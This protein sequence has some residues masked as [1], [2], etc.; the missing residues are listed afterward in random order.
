LVFKVSGHTTWSGV[1]SRKYYPAR[2][3]V[4]EVKWKTDKLFQVTRCVVEWE[5]RKGVE[6]GK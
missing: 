3:L 2:M 4:M 5:I 1:G 6:S